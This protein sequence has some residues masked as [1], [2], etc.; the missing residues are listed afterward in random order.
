MKKPTLKTHRNKAAEASRRCSAEAGRLAVIEALPEQMQ[1]HA[2]VDWE[3]VATICNYKDLETVRNNLKEAGVALVKVS[4][5]K[6]L[7]TWGAL[8]DFLKSREV[9]ARR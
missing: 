3:T 1:D 7:P 6:K 8:K 9:A 5:R 4:E 2:L